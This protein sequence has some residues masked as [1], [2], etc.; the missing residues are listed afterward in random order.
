MS[1]YTSLSPVRLSLKECAAAA[2]DPIYPFRYESILTDTYY[3]HAYTYIHNTTISPETALYVAQHC[4]LDS[5]RKR[6]ADSESAAL[7]AG[8]RICS[9][10]IIQ[11]YIEKTGHMSVLSLRH[12]ASIVHVSSLH[13]S[14]SLSVCVCFAQSHLF[15]CLCDVNAL[16]DTILCRAAEMDARRRGEVGV[17]SHYFANSASNAGRV[18]IPERA[19][20]ARL[21]VLRS[22]VNLFDT[23][24]GIPHGFGAAAIPAP[25]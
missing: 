24:G 22:N 15:C 19:R 8:T 23:V 2:H 10:G 25:S 13:I 1:L 7:T 18:N 9:E 20:A 14:F 4:L 12:D 5:R 11:H 16:T 17:M 6:R 3:R 21:A